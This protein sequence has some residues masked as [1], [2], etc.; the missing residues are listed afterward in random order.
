MAEGVQKRGGAHRAAEPA[1]GPGRLRLEPHA[2]PPARGKSN[3]QEIDGGV[4]ELL[5]DQAPEPAAGERQSDADRTAAE[6]RRVG[7]QRQLAELHL[8]AQ[9][10]V[11][12]ADGGEQRR[13]RRQAEHHVAQV[14]LAQERGAGSGQRDERE[15]ERAADPQIDPEGG[16]QQSVGDDVRLDDRVGDP[17]HQQ[18]LAGHDEQ[19]GAG[20]KAIVFG[21]EEPGQE[22]HEAEAEHLGAGNLEQTP[23]GAGDDDP[24]A[25]LPRAVLTHSQPP[26]IDGLRPARG[27]AAIWTIVRQERRAH[28]SCEC[29]I[30]WS[31]PWSASRAASP[32]RWRRPTSSGAGFPPSRR[33]R[34]S[35]RRT[36][37]WGHGLFL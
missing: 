34:L 24:R 29:R 3:H 17:A 31:S 37:V 16:V 13:Q 15:R 26:G 8:P 28:P 4:A 22:H 14:R 27:E 18:R 5:A 33:E 35:C 30:R 9:L 21:T 11:V 2:R 23:Q 10:S 6:H 20:D 12:D 19:R 7:P 1:H 25:V 32:R 36:R